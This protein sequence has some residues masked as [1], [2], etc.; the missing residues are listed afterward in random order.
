MSGKGRLTWFPFREEGTCSSIAGAACAGTREKRSFFP[1]SGAGGRICVGRGG[2][3]R[4]RGGNDRR[5]S[6][7]QRTELAAGD[8]VRI[9]LCVAPRR[10]GAGTIRV[11]GG[12]PRGGRGGT[13]RFSAASRFAR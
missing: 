12:S 11:G 13:G 8:P 10:C 9:L 2:S 3:D 4:S 6:R 7:T 1:T 5:P